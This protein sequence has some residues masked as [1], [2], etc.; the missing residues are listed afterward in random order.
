MERPTEE[1]RAQFPP[2]GSRGTGVNDSEK[3]ASTCWSWVEPQVW[4]KRM[5]TTLEQGVKGGR[6]YSLM[7]KVYKAANL[8]A[9]FRKVKANRGAAGVDHSNS[10][11]SQ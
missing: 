11:S 7:D 4:T 8:R 1:N 2:T 3:P 9:S 5:L 10:A 6:W